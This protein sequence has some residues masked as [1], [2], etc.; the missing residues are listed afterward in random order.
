L[1]VPVPPRTLMLAWGDWVGPAALVVL[2]LLLVGPPLVRRL[3]REGAAPAVPTH[4]VLLPRA[5]RVASGALRV[6]ARLC[7]LGLALALLLDEDLRSRTLAQLRWVGALVVA[8][9]LAALSLL[10]AYRTR[11][12]L[13]PGLLSFTRGAQRLE[14]PLAT[15][16][17][18]RP[19]RWPWPSAGL[20]LQLSGGA[21]WP[22]GLASRDA[23][24]LAR[25]LAA[26]GAPAA[27]PVSA[28]AQA[29]GAVAPGR[30]AH[31]LLK[32]GLLPLVLA[33]PA[34]HLHQHIA[35]GSGVGEYLSFGLKA[36]LQ[37]FARWW[38]AWGVGVL[39][40]AAVLRGAAEAMAW[41]VARWRPD[42]ALPWRRG[43]ERGAVGLLW[44]GLPA[45]L[46][47]RLVVSAG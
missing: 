20:H 6:L 15:L 32:F 10:A 47:L 24:A 8:P 9:E 31:P 25:A 1:P 39:L 37:A 14:L 35:Y 13:T 7:L 18:V 34:F 16:A 43:L 26:A 3:A 44:F 30:W 46:V 22:L 27:E 19:W 29:R 33:V 42:A 2:G 21:A 38:A 5:A 41:L 17:A 45:W 28:Y 23:A 12:S 40:A 11:L 4:V 36:Y